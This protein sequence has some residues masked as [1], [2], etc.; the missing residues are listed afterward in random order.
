MELKFR[1]LRADEIECR[2]GSTNKEKTGFSLLLYKTARTDAEI[3]DE[4]VGAWNW[5]KKF[6]QVKNT[7]VCS[8]GI[9]NENRKEWIWKD[10][11]GD[12]QTETEQIKAELS[13]SFKRASG[14]SSWG[15][16][17]EL[18]YAPFIWVKVTENNNFKGCSYSVKEIG[19]NAKREITQLTIINDE[20][21]EIV[22]SY[23]K[24]AKVSQNVPKEPKTSVNNLIDNSLQHEDTI[25][26]EDLN[27]IEAYL[28]TIKGNDMKTHAF[29]EYLIN[30]FNVYSAKNLNF[31]DG[32]KV[33]EFCRKKLA[34]GK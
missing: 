3:L 27:T 14:G 21:K 18:Y 9:Y 11:G 23:P 4:T 34:N 24:N 5:Q 7:M 31:A 25:T 30:T 2:V 1:T 15:I 8:V 13:D 28:L 6:Y 19:Y 22:Y 32:R 29:N 26:Q 20:T 17:R 12:D 33:A 16:G 10:D